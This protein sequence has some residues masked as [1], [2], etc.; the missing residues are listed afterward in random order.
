MTLGSFFFTAS[1]A[2][3]FNFL[4]FYHLGRED[5]HVPSLVAGG[6][7]ALIGLMLLVAGLLADLM[8]IN[9]KMLE[10]LRWRQFRMEEQLLSQREL[11]CP[12]NVEDDSQ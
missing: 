3:L 6:V 12:P 4:Y 5:T 8:A 1:G 10:D 2:C 11:R 9:R 7:L